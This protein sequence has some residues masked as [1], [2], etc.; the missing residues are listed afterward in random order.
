[1]EWWLIK[2]KIKEIL[3]IKNRMY[4]C[5]YCGVYMYRKVTI[6]ALPPVENAEL[7]FCCEGCK[8]LYIDSLL[9]TQV[10]KNLSIKKGVK[11]N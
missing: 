4:K 5:Q 11:H 6:K 1:M 7:N 9:P 10:R 8:E 2:N 3:G